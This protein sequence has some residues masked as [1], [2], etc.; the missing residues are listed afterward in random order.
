[1]K[2]LTW[3]GCFANDVDKSLVTAE[4]VKHPAK[5]APLLTARIFA[6]L[7]DEYGLK[8]GDHIIDPFGG[9]GITGAIGARLGYNVTL[10]ELEEFF[11]R[12]IAGH[13]CTP[14]DLCPGCLIGQDH[15]VQPGLPFARTSHQ[16][17][18]NIELYEQHGIVMGYMGSITA[19]RG[20]STHMVSL[21][22]QQ[23]R[24]YRPHAIITS[25]PYADSVRGVGVGTGARYDHQTHNADTAESASSFNG[26]GDEVGQIGKLKRGAYWTAVSQVYRQC[27]Q[28]LPPGRPLVV[29]IKSIIRDGKII[30]L[31]G[32][33]ISLLKDIGFYIPEMAQ[34]MVTEPEVQLSLMADVPNKRKA[35]ETLW[36]RNSRKNG[37]AIDYEAVIFA[38]RGG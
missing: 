7:R 34:A 21:L 17:H 12:C 30:D 31:P 16:Y 2:T 38:V 1:M 33:T 8:H 4:S 6:H 19:V 13:Y 32:K 23:D 26:Y 11:Y 9:V 29:V 24:L 15:K 35:H 10:I 37:L 36:R 27:H 18:G 28:A 22:K 25:P 3:W 20:D 5:M 14:D